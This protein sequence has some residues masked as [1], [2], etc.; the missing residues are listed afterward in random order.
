MGEERSDCG[1][2][3]KV[4]HSGCGLPCTR[5]RHIRK[6]GEASPECGEMFDGNGMNIQQSARIMV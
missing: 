6:E 1:S 4:S 5:W 3:L 2:E